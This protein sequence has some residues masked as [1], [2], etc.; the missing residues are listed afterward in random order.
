MFKIIFSLL[1][2]CDICFA[3]IVRQE[4]KVP[5]TVFNSNN[6]QKVE[7]D[8]VVTIIRDTVFKKA[9]Y[10][11]LNHGRTGTKEERA[12]QSFRPYF[13]NA[14]YFARKGF[15]VIMPLRIGY[16]NTGGP[17]VE[18]SGP[19]YNK[20]YQDATKS[21]VE[22]I[23]QVINSVS[24]LEYIDKSKGLVVGHSVGGLV[25]VAFSGEDITGLKGTVNFAGGNGG[26]TRDFLRE[27]PCSAQKL[28]ETFASYGFK[29][30]VPTLWLYSV[31]DQFWGEKLPKEWFSSFQKNGGKGRMLMLPESG[32]DGHQVFI[33]RPN[34]WKAEFEKFIKEVGL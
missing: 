17:D 28:T 27:R 14:E 26:D 12:K 11:I 22:E 19:C 6:K 25:S 33:D 31:N 30:K 16:G 8:V 5:V 9:P 4:I 20:N 32:G 10:L 18:F 13:V 24:N 1:L 34:L 23:K 2:F 7:E 21:A 29:S 3:D 15:V